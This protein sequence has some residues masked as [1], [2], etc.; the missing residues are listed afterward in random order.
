MLPKNPDE[1]AIDYDRFINAFGT[2]S[3]VLK[4]MDEMHELGSVFCRELISREFLTNHNGSFYQTP[5][6]EQILSEIA[7]V[8]LLIDQMAFIFGRPR[9]KEII[10]EKLERA[11]QAVK[12]FEEDSKR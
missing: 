5:S 7:D 2:Q 11:L 12:E 1:M 8:Y 10:A 6:Y 3:Q 9:V 4:M